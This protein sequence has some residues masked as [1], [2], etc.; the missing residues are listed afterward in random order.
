MRKGETMTTKELELTTTDGEKFKVTLVVSKADKNGKS[1]AYLNFN[2][3]NN[4][5]VTFEGKK[6]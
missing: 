4:E 6:E 1:K 5:W 2:L 3:P